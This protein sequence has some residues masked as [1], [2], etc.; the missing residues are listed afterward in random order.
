M[1]LK[2]NNQNC[3][4]ER[5]FGQLLVL[6]RKHNIDLNKVMTYPLNPVPWALAT[7]DEQLMKTNKAVLMHKLEQH[8]IQE[9]QESNANSVSIIDGNT[10]F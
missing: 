5:R 4:T 6:S 2:Q 8:V 9:T 1:E 10:L 7:S 3:S